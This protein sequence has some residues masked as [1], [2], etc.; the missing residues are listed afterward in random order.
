MHFT[1]DL[2]KMTTENT[3]PVRYILDLENDFF[4]LNKIIGKKIS[5]KY[6]HK[7]KCFC[8]KLVD[9]VYRQNFC[10]DCYYKLPQAS[11][12]I[13]KPELCKAHL[14]IEVRD[15]EWE[16]EF[17]LKPHIVYLAVSSGLKVGITRKTQIPTRWIDQ[18]AEYAIEFAEVPNRY[19]SGAIEVALKQYVSDKTSWQKML[20]NPSP[21]VD[22][23]EWKNK[24]KE[25]M[26]EETK[27][28]FLTERNEVHTIKFPIEKYPEKVK[29]VNLTKQDSFEGVLKGIKGQYLI[30]EGG[31]VFNVRSHEGYIVDI[32]L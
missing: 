9:K 17:E 11:E 18:G 6:Q 25:F 1:G 30:F 13:M 16:K 14:G 24:L 23:L 10:Y 29:S 3:N 2:K 21:E 5:I 19:L 31:M 12:S 27:Q 20:K 8:G 28:Y 22:L 32:E 7:V 4:E 15:L 26:P